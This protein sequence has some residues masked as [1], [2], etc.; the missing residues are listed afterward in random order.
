MKVEQ[1][2]H[3]EDL[4]VRFL[5]FKEFSYT[6]PLR[7]VHGWGDFGV[8]APLRDCKTTPVFN[9]ATQS[10]ESWELLT[11]AAADAWTSLSPR[12]PPA[13][14]NPAA[15]FLFS[16]YVTE[17]LKWLVS[18][19]K[20]QPALSEPHRGRRLNRKPPSYFVTHTNKRMSSLHLELHSFIRL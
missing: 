4:P 20:H 5:Q 3:G 16:L 15:F 14:S 11:A 1:T 6:I 8:D 18:R 2:A 7:E 10:G 12:N 17:H 9:T 19:F 13:V